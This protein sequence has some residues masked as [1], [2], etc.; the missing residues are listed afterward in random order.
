[1]THGKT[2]PKGEWTLANIITFSRGLAPA[3]SVCYAPW[4]TPVVATC[5]AL[6]A[7]RPNPGFAALQGSDRGLHQPTTFLRLIS[8]V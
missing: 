8:A 4:I 3:R 5:A 6:G 7:G 2:L 1:M